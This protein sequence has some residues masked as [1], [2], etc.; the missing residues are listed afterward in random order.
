VVV[1]SNPFDAA[2]LLE[3]AAT[4][5]DP[6]LILLP[7]H[8]FRV[9]HPAGRERAIAIG[10]AAL[11]RPGDDVTIVAWGNCVDLALNA[12]ALLAR[13]EIDAEVIDMVSLSPCDWNNIERSVRTTG[14]L[15]VIT[16][17]NRTCSFGQA[18][19]AEAA[20]NPALWPSFKAN[21]LLISRGDVH[22]PFHPKLERALLPDAARVVAEVI[23]LVR[24]S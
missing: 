20:S 2:A 3:L 13:Q 4:G 12:A 6:I 24:N 15:V 18:I 19:I 23:Q 21:P 10:Q 9:R 7:K 8:Q 11:R 17:D 22:V 1:P 5:D 14:R 16:E